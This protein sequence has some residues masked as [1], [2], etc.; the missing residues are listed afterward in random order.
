M[1]REFSKHQKKIVDRYYEHHDTIQTTKLSELVTELYLCGDAKKQAA[2]W[3]R[4]E[5]AL[6][7]LEVT[8]SRLE[9]V[10]QSKDVTKLAKLVEDVQAG[11]AGGQKKS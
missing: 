2:L 4:A 10:L 11:R 1:A 6:R 8:P 9:L 7:R 3:N 5:Q